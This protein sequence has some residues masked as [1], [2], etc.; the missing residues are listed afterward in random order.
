MVFNI[1][2]SP[3]VVHCLGIAKNEKGDCQVNIT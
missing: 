1:S 3:A 2:N